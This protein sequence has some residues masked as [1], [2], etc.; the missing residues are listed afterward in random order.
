[1]TPE[2]FILDYN[3]KNDGQYSEYDTNYEMMVAFANYHLEL[4]KRNILK[5]ARIVLQDGFKC[6]YYA[7]RDKDGNLRSVEIDKKSI[8]DACHITKI[9]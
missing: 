2:K 3:R 1:M 6:I 7:Y 8:T 9:E 5:K 4:Q